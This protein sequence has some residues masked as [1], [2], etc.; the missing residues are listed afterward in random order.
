MRAFVFL[1]IKHEVCPKTP[2]FYRRKDHILYNEGS[3]FSSPCD[4]AV[5]PISGEIGIV[6]DR[7]SGFCG[8][9]PDRNE[10][11]SV[12]SDAECEWVSVIQRN[13]V[14]TNGTGDIPVVF[15]HGFGCDSTMW[16]FVEPSF[17]SEYR[18]ILYDLT[19]CGKSDLSEYDFVRYSSLRG[20]AL[21]LL[22]LL[23]ELN[24]HEVIFVGHS[25]SAMIGL[26]AARQEPDR[27]QRLIMLGGSAC[28]VNR[29]G[30][31]G[32]FDRAEVDGL[33]DTLDLN[34]LGWARTMAPLVMGNPDRPELS[35]ELSRAYCSNDPKLPATLPQLRFTVTAGMSCPSVRYPR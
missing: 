20:Y 18:T 22:D 30:Y 1:I 12:A 28:Y 2:N 27:F 8:K 7:P 25:V 11:V 13:N 17:R 9:I 3:N 32:G 15:A 14:Q 6:S 35:Q 16:R 5:I 24:L 34:Y 4:G 23:R 33:L 29:D 26:L 21:D 31:T 10:A 19:G